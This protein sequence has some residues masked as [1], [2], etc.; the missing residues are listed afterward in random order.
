MR[1]VSGILLRLMLLTF[2]LVAVFGSLELGLRLFW[3]GFYV[4]PQE[5]YTELDPVRG[6]R[7]RPD[8]S[9]VFAAPE[10][11]TVVS[12]NAWGYRGAPLELE[13][14]EGRV[15]CSGTPSRTDMG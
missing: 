3:G 7:N 4:K 5:P 15:W 9:V 10:F 11:S 12:N 6:W 13:R 1:M 2:S 8:V 14:S